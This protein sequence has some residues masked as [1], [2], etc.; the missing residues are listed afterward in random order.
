MPLLRNRKKTKNPF[1]R[2]GLLEDQSLHSQIDDSLGLFYINLTILDASSAIFEKIHTKLSKKRLPRRLVERISKQA[3]KAVPNTLV[4]KK[5]SEKLPK[6]LMYKMASKGLTIL[7]ETVY[8]EEYYV[9][10]QVQVQNVDTVILAESLNTT[11][12]DDDDHSVASDVVDE[13][14]EH[15]NVPNRYPI[16]DRLDGQCYPSE[17]R[18]RKSW[19]A[20]ILERLW[21]LFNPLLRATIESQMLPNLI[22]RGLTQQ[23]DTIL[24]AKMNEKNLKALTKV[25]METEQARYFF[26]HLRILREE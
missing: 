10:I 2:E 24:P 20:R 13:W 21:N 7:A 1:E 19:L 26:E 6:N 18:Q 9:V 3:S 4:A 16:T 15:R 5:L 25:L 17:S 14:M 23:M 12:T 22:V 11:S 8:V